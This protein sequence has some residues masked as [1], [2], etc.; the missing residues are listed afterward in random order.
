MKVE[1]TWDN[2][3]MYEEN[4]H[5]NFSDARLLGPGQQAALT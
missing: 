1:G 3:G 2:L 5:Q 4:K